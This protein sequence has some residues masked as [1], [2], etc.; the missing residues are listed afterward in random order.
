MDKL[1]RPLA[2]WY[3][4]KVEHELAK[5]GL[6]YEDILNDS[7]PDIQTAILR[8]SPEEISNRNKRLKRALDI[9][10][11]HAELSKEAQASVQPFV[12]YLPLQRARDERLERLMNK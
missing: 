10:L 1:L 3:G 9:S 7:H 12:G 8:L 5:Y 6:K 2:M 4:R 11:K